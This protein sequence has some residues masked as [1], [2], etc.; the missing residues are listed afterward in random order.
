MTLKIL[1]AAVAAVS[2]AMPVFAADKDKDQEQPQQKQKLI[3]RTD[4]ATGSLTRKVRT[5]KTAD[6]WRESNQKTREAVDNFTHDA[7][8]PQQASNPLGG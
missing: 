3:C 1:L 8:A 4:T 7:A 6:E 2:L 5:C